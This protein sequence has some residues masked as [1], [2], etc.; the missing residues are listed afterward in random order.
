VLYADGGGRR[1]AAL[2]P[3]LGRERILRFFAGIASKDPDIARQRFEPA[4]INGRPGLLVHERAGTTFAIGFEVR[5][6]RIA[7]IYV[8]LNPDKLVGLQRAAGPGRADG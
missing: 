5:D 1:T 3:I 7:A 8:V 6:E 2:R 4:A